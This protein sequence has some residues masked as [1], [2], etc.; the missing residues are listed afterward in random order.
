MPMAKNKT[1]EIPPEKSL[2]ARFPEIANEWNY[3]KNGDLTPW[4]V[5]PGSI[6]KVWWLYS[7]DD[8]ET[9]N[10]YDFEWDATINN[11]TSHDTGCPYLTGQKVWPG[12]NDLATKRPDLAAQWHPKKNGDLTPRDVSPGSVKRVWWLYS[13][14]DPETGNH[15]DFGWDATINDRVTKDS[16]C[17]YLAGKKVWPGFNDLATKRP[18]LAAQWNYT[19]N[20]SL[21][22]ENVTAGSQKKVWWLYPYDDPE[23]GKHFDFEWDAT[24]SERVAGDSSCPYLTGRRV[25]PGFNDLATKRP[26]L[27][28]QW[29]YTKNGSLTPENVT[30][31]SQKKVW[32]LYP[33]DDPETGKHFDFEWDAVISNR[34][35]ND[36]GC[37]YL[38]G[39]KV[40]PGFNDLVTRRPDLA[41]Q[42]NY[43]K[44]GD[45]TPDNVVVGSGKKVWWLYPYDDPETGKH[46]DFEWEAI[47]SNRMGNDQGCPYLVGKKVWPGFNDLA[48]KRPDLAALWH[49]TK[50]GKLT[51]ETVIYSSRKNVW[52]YQKYT[53]PKT[54]E[55]FEFE[56]P[57]VVRVC[58]RAKEP[59]P[60]LRNDAVWPGYNDLETKAP[61]LAA[62]WDYEKNRGLKP[63]EVVYSSKNK[64]WWK[65]PDCGGSW[66]MT[67]YE[68]VRSGHGCP[69]CNRGKR[70][71]NP[72]KDRRTS[73][74]ITPI[75]L[76]RVKTDIK[77]SNI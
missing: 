8:P 42:W 59:N 27:A 36:T 16:G 9:G 41:A 72:A 29:N 43:T 19:K 4:N 24:I 53:D 60:Y 34:T 13:Y 50:N 73:S 70:L 31:G 47:I 1:K 71:I 77:D 54:G 21:T 32:W 2:A 7:Y 56:W 40:W 45:L 51:P 35:G 69:Y 3:T 64:Y 37:P 55:T 46:F 39:K 33:Y 67:A 18:D 62:Q 75:R 17:P 14:D 61:E 76:F 22:P 49:P 11:R 57:C 58:T 66:Y 20:G 48:T 52:W 5:S 15:Y 28:V 26:D 6:K 65:C 12:F 10:H 23:T 38:T 25:W 74:D 63:C 44:N 68:R 30:A